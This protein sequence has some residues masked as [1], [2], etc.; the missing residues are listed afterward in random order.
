MTEPTPDPTRAPWPPGELHAI[1][2]DQAAGGAPVIILPASRGVAEAW[3][4]R[5]FGINSW[6][7]IMP[8]RIEYD[9]DPRGTGT[10]P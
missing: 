4:I 10:S 9:F 8:A 5:T 3:A 2:P 6:W 7:S 1:V